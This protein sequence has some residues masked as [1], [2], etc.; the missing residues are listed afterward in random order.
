MSRTSSGSSR[1]S[2]GPAPVGV[3]AVPAAV[4]V[5]PEAVLVDQ[6]G[7]GERVAA[8]LLRRDLGGLQGRGDHDESMA[9]GVEAVTGRGQGG[10][11]AGAGGALHH[12]QARGAEQRADDV[13]LRPGRAVGERRRLRRRRAL[14]RARR[15]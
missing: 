7:G 4:V 5:P 11:L 8:D 15:A 2:V 14:P 9:V 12:D 13:S 3:D 1:A 10:G 6:P